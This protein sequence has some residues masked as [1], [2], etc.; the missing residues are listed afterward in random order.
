MLTPARRSRS[1]S[2]SL[3]LRRPACTQATAMKK[4]GD[5]SE[6][7]FS[8][9]VQ[10]PE[11]GTHSRMCSKGS[12]D[13]GNV[14][15]LGMDVRRDSH[16]SC[17]D[18]R[19]TR[20]DNSQAQTSPVASWNFRESCNRL[21]RPNCSFMQPSF[22]RPSC[23]IRPGDKIAAV[24]GKTMEDED[25]VAELEAAANS[26]ITKAVD[27]TVE[28][29]MLDVLG[30]ARA[31]HGR[32]WSKSSANVSDTHG[33]ETTTSEAPV[34]AVKMTPCS[35]RLD[36]CR[37]PK[38]LLPPLPLPGQI[39]CCAEFSAGDDT[40]TRPPS[41]RSSLSAGSCPGVFFRHCEAVFALQ[42]SDSGSESTD[43][44]HHQHSHLACAC[45]P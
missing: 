31:H 14:S 40:S 36:T 16:S 43:N 22:R 13:G 21:H 2:T 3:Q 38:L 41:S 26:T 19:V 12:S 7:T 28:R 45:A 39:D 42:Q 29:P 4:R 17:S 1:S 20:V 5:L 30:P 11:L 15:R 18:L 8:F 33:P 23:A 35:P 25:I 6:A 34:P 44:V 32:S 9:A 37:F 27:L 10:L 24:N